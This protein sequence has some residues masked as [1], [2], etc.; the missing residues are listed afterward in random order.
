MHRILCEGGPTLLDELVQAD[1]VTEICEISALSP[2][3][4]AGVTV[5]ARHAANG[6]CS[7]DENAR[8]ERC[9]NRFA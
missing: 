7:Y 3:T 2:A 1:A 6:A 9:A 4:F 5:S 8:C